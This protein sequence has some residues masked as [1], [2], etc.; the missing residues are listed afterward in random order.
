MIDTRVVKDIS[1]TV[2]LCKTFTY[3][4]TLTFQ[5]NSGKVIKDIYSEE[6]G[7]YTVIF[8]DNTIFNFISDKSV[9]HG[10]VIGNSLVIYTGDKV[11]KQVET[12]R[13]Y[14]GAVIDLIAGYNDGKPYS[15]FTYMEINKGEENAE[16]Y[17]T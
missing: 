13:V 9:N 15:R 3:D 10:E 1:G 17:T 8:T 7:E 11:L 16:N 5:I 14:G 12:D 2:D 6:Q 4:N